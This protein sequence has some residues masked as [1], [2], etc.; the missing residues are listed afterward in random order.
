MQKNNRYQLR[1]FYHTRRLSSGGLGFGLIGWQV[2]DTENGDEMVDAFR[3]VRDA[4]KCAK[5]LN[6]TE[7]SK[8]TN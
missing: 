8:T 2:I 4:I 6:E 7:T 1:R 3:L 5:T